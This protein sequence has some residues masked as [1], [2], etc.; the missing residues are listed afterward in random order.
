M[1][2]R[3][4]EGAEEGTCARSY[5]LFDAQGYGYPDINNQSEYQYNSNREI[6]EE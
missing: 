5:C 3:K 6:P 2:C 1:R 4:R